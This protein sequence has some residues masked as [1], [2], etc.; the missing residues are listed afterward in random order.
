MSTIDSSLS[1]ARDW[2]EGDW[3]KLSSGDYACKA[4]IN[5]KYNNR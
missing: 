2:P 5:E 1:L 4:R 3:R